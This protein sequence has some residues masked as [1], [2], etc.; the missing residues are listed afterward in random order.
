MKILIVCLGN[1]CRSPMA[2]AVLQSK[3]GDDYTVDS[4]GTISLHEGEQPDKRAIKTSQKMGMDI[5]SQKS[6]PITPRDF[7]HFDRILCMDV[8]VFEDVIAKA[9]NPEQKKKVGLFLE[10]GEIADRKDVPDP[11]WGGEQEFQDVYQLIDVASSRIAE[12][13]KERQI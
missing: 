5:S 13:I 1:I 2:E 10:E 9:K 3:L 11:Y 7:E 4:C 12:K 8:S 6:R